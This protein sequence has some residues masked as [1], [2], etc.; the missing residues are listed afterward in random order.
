MMIGIGCGASRLVVV[1][2]VGLGWVGGRRYDEN[3]KGG[4]S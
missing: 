1:V 2:V 4:E 3:D